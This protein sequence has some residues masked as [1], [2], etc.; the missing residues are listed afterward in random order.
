VESIDDEI[1]R[2][3]DA[4]STRSGGADIA[5]VVVEDPEGERPLVGTAVI[6]ADNRQVAYAKAALDAVNRRLTRRA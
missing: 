6:D 2:L 1:Y 4:S 5:L 3:V